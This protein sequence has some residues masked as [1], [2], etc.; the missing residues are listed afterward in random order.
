MS[1]PYTILL[2]EDE[3]SMVILIKY[4]LETEGYRFFSVKNGREA[5]DFCKKQTPDL[6]ISDIGMPEMDGFELR[7]KLIDDERLRNIPF[8]Y[9]TAT[10][11]SIDHYKGMSLGVNHFLTKPFEP[12]MLLITIKDIF[13]QENK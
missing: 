1:K 3:Q 5:I 13:N 10:T 9:L 4:N 12:E 8:I 6:I 2:V 7:Q 11:Q